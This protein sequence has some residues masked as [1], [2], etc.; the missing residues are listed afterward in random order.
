M[1]RVFPRKTKWTPT[2]D[3]AF[4]GEPP[5]WFTHNAPDM[6]VHVSVTFTWDRDRGMK[7]ADAWS[8]YL[9]TRI[10]GPAF[11]DRGEDF[12]AGRYIKEGVTIT[13][14]GCPKK[15]PWCLVPGRE[16]RGHPREL[17]IVPGHIVQDNNLL[18]CSDKHILKVF[19]MLRMQKEPIKFSGGL[20]IDYLKKWHV[21]WLHFFRLDE[22]WVAFDSDQ[23]VQD[24]LAKAKELLADFSI[25][26]KR[27]YVLIGYG[28]DTPSAARRRLETVYQ[29]GFLPFAMPY[30]GPD[31]EFKW[32]AGAGLQPWKDLVRHWSRPAIYRRKTCNSSSISE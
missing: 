11:G 15:C 2:D 32:C 9:P 19:D 18:A 1:I 31:A 28:D 24:N 12:V 29:A 3:L 26:K 30:K 17:P 27:A 6:P 25:E 5:L 21:G 16:G 23:A 14:R 13:S 10:G 8:K 7:L 22:I 20:D 4:V